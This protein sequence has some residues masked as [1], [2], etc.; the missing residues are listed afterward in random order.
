MKLDRLIYKNRYYILAAII[1]LNFV[2]KGIFISSTSIAGD[3]PFSIYHAQM[4]IKY[5]IKLL[6]TGNNPP[7][8]EILLHFWIKLFGIS[9]LSVRMPSLIFST[10]TVFYVFRIGFKYFNLRIGIVASLLFIFSNYQTLYAHE[11]RVYT[12]FGML[13]TISMF[14]FLSLVDRQERRWFHFGILT[15]TNIVLIY[16][17]YFGFFVLGIEFTFILVSKELRKNLWKQIL[18]STL[19]IFIAYIPNIKIITERFL[20][21][22]QNGTWLTKPNGLASLYT[23]IVKF[24]NAPVVAVTTITILLISLGIYIVKRENIEIPKTKLLIAVWFAIPFIL[25]FCISYFIPMYLDR[26]LI[27]ISS[28]FVILIPIAIE[29]LTNNKKIS[30]AILVVTCLLFVATT[31]TNI[32]NKRNVKETV[33]KIKEIKN[34]STMVVINPYHFVLN[35]AYYYDLEIFKKIKQNDTYSAIEK[36]LVAQNI[37]ATYNILD[38]NYSKYS[39]I[40]FLDAAANLTNPQNPMVNE[41]LKEYTIVNT[42]MFYEVFMIYELR[43][44]M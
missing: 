5:I 39:H 42:Y 14:H 15:L 11:A 7:L 32:T 26:Y 6:S 21:S 13:S 28:S 31:K 2:V 37:F 36:E 25:M 30:T 43:K 22:S 27:F 17:H 38:I 16:S 23:M 9:E 3:E 41:L 34:D 20:D 33:Q 18:A 35:F 12:M 24:A 10:I 8:Y 19:L 40:L 4:N 1:V 29:S 44:T